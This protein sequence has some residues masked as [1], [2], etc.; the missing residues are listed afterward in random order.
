MEWKRACKG[1]GEGEGKKRI[2]SI[3]KWE[4]ERRH[5]NGMGDMERDTGMKK[6]RGGGTRDI[7]RVTE[8]E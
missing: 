7:D 3:K 5:G 1:K 4:E 2:L 6:K 8:I